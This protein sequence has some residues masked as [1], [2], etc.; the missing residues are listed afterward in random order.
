METLRLNMRG[1]MVRLLQRALIRAGILSGAQDGIFGQNTLQAVRELQ[2]AAGLTAD[3]IVGARTWR[4]LRP[5]L[6]R[7]TRYTLRKGD[8]PA[9]IAAAHGIGASALIAANPESVFLAG[10]TITVPTADAAI[11]TDIEY[12]YGILLADI[13]A[14][15]ARYPFLGKGTLGE[16]VMGKSLP[17]LRY[18]AGQTRVFY[19]ASHHANE[20]ITTPVLMRFI[21]EL[22]AAKVNRRSVY[23]LDARSAYDAVSLYAAPMVNPDGVDLVTGALQPNTQAYRYAYSIRDG[24]PFPTAWKANLRGVDLNNN[25]P[26]LFEEGYREKYD[27][28]INYPRPRD[29]TGPYALSEPESQSMARLTGELSPA[30]TISLHT[31]G[32]EIYYRFNGITPPGAQKIGEAMVAATSGYTLADPPGPSYGGYKDW[33]I[34]DFYRPGYTLELG[35]GQNPLPMDSFASVYAESAPM[36]AE[37]I[38]AI[39]RN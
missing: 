39:I 17:I 23:G 18:G 29:Y 4:A 15:G 37:A 9:S 34:Q 33:F 6:E 31:Q 7:T 16:S 1:P 26:A 12:S 14:L 24:F 20:Y 36:L 22:C 28:G 2:R 19:N 25:Y 27:L 11:T 13:Y 38:R 3:G 32:R 10:E 35:S 21:E 5:L 30:L 8:T